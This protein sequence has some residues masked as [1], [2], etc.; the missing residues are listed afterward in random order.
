MK[1]DGYTSHR[2]ATQQASSR[3]ERSLARLPLSSTAATVEQEVP[4]A[5]HEALKLEF[6]ALQAR[7]DA[8]TSAKAELQA[9]LDAEVAKLQARLDA[10]AGAKAELQAEN[11]VLRA[12]LGVAEVDGEATAR[13]HPQLETEAKE[14]AKL[15]SEMVVLRGEN[16]ALQASLAAAQDSASKAREAARGTPTAAELAAEVQAKAIVRDEEAESACTFYFVPVSRLL[17]GEANGELTLP[18]FQELLTEGALVERTLTRSECYRAMHT[19]KVLA[20]SHRWERPDAPDTQ[21]VQ[22]KAILDHVRGTDVELVWFEC[23]PPRSPH[24]Y[25]HMHAVTRPAAFNYPRES[26]LTAAHAARLLR[27]V[28]DDRPAL[29]HPRAATGACHRASA[30]SQSA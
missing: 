8:E 2:G 30:C 6:N 17:A 10:E 12:R 14:V 15:Q 16:A 23:A 4:A 5:E 25:M 9:R 26:S 29:L 7:L 22:T 19:R 18:R 20:I 21:G 13:P 28:C 1:S 24:L 27:A 11:M 3:L